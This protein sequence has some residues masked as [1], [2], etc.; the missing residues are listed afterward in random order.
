MYQALTRYWNCTGEHHKEAPFPAG[1]NGV[2]CRDW[3]KFPSMIEVSC[4]TN[5][6]YIFV[7]LCPC[8]IREI[9][10]FLILDIRYPTLK[11]IV[12]TRATCAENDLMAT[13]LGVWVSISRKGSREEDL[14]LHKESIRNDIPTWCMGNLWSVG[15]SMRRIIKPLSICWGKF[16]R[17]LPQSRI[18]GIS[19]DAEIP[20][21]KS[22]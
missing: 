12:Y 16:Q 4:F 22:I 9:I 17:S 2:D 21:E 13:C 20:K 8:R 1:G 18:L 15:L 10:F 19:C 5:Q 14:K 3:R 6:R 11:M 7:E